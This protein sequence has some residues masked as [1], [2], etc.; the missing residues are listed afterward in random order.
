MPLYASIFT[1]LSIRVNSKY[2]SADNSSAAFTLK[3]HLE[4][5]PISGIAPSKT[6]SLLCLCHHKLL[7]SKSEPIQLSIW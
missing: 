7:N 5:Q 2:V 6:L 3:K 1:T 4:R